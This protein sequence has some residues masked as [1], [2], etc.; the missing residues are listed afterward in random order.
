MKKLSFLLIILFY[1]CS[2]TQLRESWFNKEYQEYKP[3]NIL[4]IGVTPNNDARNTF[5]EKLKNEFIE[6]DINA[7][8]STIVFED[9]FKDSKQTETEIENQVQILL[10]SGYDTIIVSAVKSV[11]EK[12]ILTGQSP[13][14]DYN[15][16]KFKTYYLLNQ[17]TFFEENTYS[18][19]KVYHIETSIYNIKKDNEKSLVW[20]GYYNI[21]DPQN[22][23]K[24]ING[25]V[26]AITKALEKE[27]L[28]PKK[29]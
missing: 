29:K 28:I 10:S 4:I 20:V 9:A 18:N 24:T 6:R 13:K 26:K 23:K 25:Y 16:R 15:L 17:D 11:E 14:A 3:E 7:L 22:T 12:R 1:S 8:K 2:S 27:T 19:Y 5:E 21:V